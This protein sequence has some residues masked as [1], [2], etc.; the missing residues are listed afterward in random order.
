[1]KRRTD[2]AIISI[3]LTNAFG[4]IRRK[5]IWDG[6][7]QYAPELLP[8][9]RST[10]G[11]STKL[12]NSRREFL[13]A[14]N[15]GIKQGDC[16]GSTFFCIGIQK[17]LLDIQY[18]I[19]EVMGRTNP[20]LSEE[21]AGVIAYID[22]ITMFCPRNSV[23]DIMSRLQTHFGAI[24]MTMSSTKSCIYGTRFGASHVCGTPVVEHGII[25]L[26]APVSIDEEFVTQ[27]VVKLV[28][29]A[30][31]PLPALGH[32]KPWCA[33]TLLKQCINLRL[34]YLTRV[35]SRREANLQLFRKFDTLI[36]KAL[37]TIIRFDTSGI[38]ESD[39][40]AVTNQ[41]KF[42]FQMRALPLEM[43]GLGMGR[44]GGM[45]GT[46]ASMRSDILF[47][48]HL[49]R[50]YSVFLPTADTDW[51][52]NILGLSEQPPVRPN[53]AATPLENVSKKYIKEVQLAR[54]EAIREELCASRQ[55]KRA[56]WM[57]S[58]A[59]KGSGSWIGGITGMLYP[60]YAIAAAEEFIIALR[61]RMLISPYGVGLNV[62]QVIRCQ[63]G[64]V[65]NLDS[66][67]LHLLDCTG[68][69]GFSSQRHTKICTLLEDHLR[70]ALGNNGEV[71]K[72]PTVVQGTK[73]DLLIRRGLSSQM[74]DI[75]ICNPSAASYLAVGA[76]VTPGVAAARRAMDKRGHY[77]QEIQRA[78]E[79]NNS[80]SSS[81]S[82]STA[83]VV[84]NTSATLPGTDVIPLVWEA[85]GRPGPEVEHFLETQFNKEFTARRKIV[86]IQAQALSVK[87]CVKAIMA[88]HE[89][90][91]RHPEDIYAN[92]PRA[93]PIEAGLRATL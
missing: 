7:A 81:S 19:R 35:V 79:V 38:N 32:L 59:F 27:Q 28:R 17:T 30:A 67:Y 39:T 61:M 90:L 84:G 58:Q 85:T 88:W 31:A 86:S 5:A 22:D 51:G 87:F 4:T 42:G 70:G 15:T 52:G 48:T 71:L 76:A 62:G 13:G 10:Y 25:C 80:S 47:N 83:A 53:P 91:K 18:M 45:A 40:L 1:M 43:G 57:T 11:Q 24:G 65:V 44:H 46:V 2:Y 50:F 16:I 26:G 49:S 72:E 75:A 6:L 82:S 9:F 93:P 3:D 92:A 33:L 89:L 60:P 73:A 12:F 21:E 23:E 37:L 55:F 36:D 34:Q 74:I 64:C 66:D 68:V 41:L 54:F 20:S 69:R 63:C 8:F 29:E 14:V 78:R 56:A 77:A